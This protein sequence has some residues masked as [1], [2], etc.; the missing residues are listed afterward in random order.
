M[1][2]YDIVSLSGYDS[3]NGAMKF[4][5]TEDKPANY[6]LLQQIEAV[7]HM[8]SPLWPVLHEVELYFVHSECSHQL[9]HQV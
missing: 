1:Y 2:I 9:Q 6:N 8:T 4:Q 7:Q 5:N 3:I